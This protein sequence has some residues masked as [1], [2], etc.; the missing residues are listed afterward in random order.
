MLITLREMLDE[1]KKGKYGVGMF[2]AFNI[3]LARGVMEAAEE[4]RSPVIFSTAEALLPYCD[5]EMAASFLLP[6]LKKATIP[7]VLHLDHGFADGV[8][9]KAIEVGFTSVMYDC[10]TR[11]YE[12]NVALCADMTDFAHKKGV[13]VEGE[14][15]HVAFDET[16]SVGSGGYEYTKVEEVRDFAQRTKV[17]ALAIAIG[18]EHGPYSEKPVLDLKRLAE[19]RENTDTNLVL[20]GGSGLSD[21]AFRDCVKNGIQ[22]INIY[23]DISYAASRAAHDFV[24]HNTPNIHEVSEAMREAVKKATIEKLMIFGCAGKG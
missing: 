9:K 20:H 8:L 3:E 18:T 19:I 4:T 1:A 12:E 17:D 14:L 21:D 16:G 11:P 13:S 6:M 15:G 7:V 2:N 5:L 22:K 10:S 23:T 24:E